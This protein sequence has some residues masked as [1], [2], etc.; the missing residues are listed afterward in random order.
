M[1]DVFDALGERKRREILGILATGEQSAGDV[2]DAMQVGGPISQPTVSQ[3]LKVL[4]ESGLVTM[5]AEGTRRVYAI[6]SA[7]IGRARLWLANLNDPAP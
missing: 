3:H 4:R 6:D 1:D 5:R 2:V 7:V